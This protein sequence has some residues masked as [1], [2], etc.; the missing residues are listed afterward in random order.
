M[1]PASLPLQRYRWSYCTTAGTPVIKLK[2]K[3][4]KKTLKKRF[5][6]PY[7][8][9]FIELNTSKIICFFPPFLAAPTA[10]GSSWAR[11]ESG[12]AG[13]LTHWARDQTSNSTV[14][15]SIYVLIYSIIVW[16]LTGMQT[17]EEKDF[18]LY[19][20]LALSKGHGIQKALNKDVEW[21][22]FIERK[23]GELTFLL[24][25]FSFWCTPT[26]QPTN[27]PKQVLT[28]NL[29]IYQHVYQPDKSKD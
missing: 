9:S 27:P 28:T 16:L 25:P 3:K 13:S 22:A 11:T 21:M 18:V 26:I 14:G 17:S 29:W 15:T 23:K 7:F 2:R 4:K 6:N 8:V 12:N 10:N 24:F 1:E 20:S 19:Y 5:D